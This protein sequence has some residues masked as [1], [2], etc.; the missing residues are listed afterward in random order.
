M[1]NVYAIGC[2][3]VAGLGLGESARAGLLARSFAEL[4]RLARAMN[5]QRRKR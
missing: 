2:G 4:C 3:I 1:K 5:T